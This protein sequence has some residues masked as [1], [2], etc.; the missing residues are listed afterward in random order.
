MRPVIRLQHLGLLA[1]GL[2][3]AVVLL[4]G[5][6]QV[7]SWIAR[8]TLDRP[9]WTDS[10]DRV[11]V[12]CLGDSNTYG[13]YLERNQAYPKQLE[14]RWNERMEQPKLQVVNFGYPG[15]NSSHVLDNLDE[16]LELFRPQIV[17]LM[18]G[19]NDFWTLPLANAGSRR[20]PFW[21]RYSRLYRLLLT[22]L[23][24]PDPGEVEF[25]Q[26][27]QDQGA[28]NRLRVGNHEFDAGYQARKGHTAPSFLKRNLLERNLVL[29]VQRLRE[30]DVPVHLM[31]YPAWVGLYGRANRVIRAVADQTRTPLI[32]Q[33]AVFRKACPNSACPKLLFRDFH[34]RQPGYA[35]VADA[36]VRQL[37][38]E[39]APSDRSAAARESRSAQSRSSQTASAARSP[40]TTA[41]S[42]DGSTR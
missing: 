6:L 12:L 1:F 11:R 4:E 22:L 2:L 29:L 31:T 10:G 37:A 8:A 33:E 13:V 34:P 26:T 39:L 32:D 15:A 30:R 21:K 38:E 20:P 14:E 25:V 16:A 17:L 41:P 36:I 35:L 18:V 7:A 3:L 19:A 28:G 24:P 5:G 40:A 9:V 27:P 42:K 23:P